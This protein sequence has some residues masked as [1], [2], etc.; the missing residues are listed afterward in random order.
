VLVRD[1]LG[2]FDADSIRVLLLRQHYRESWEYT[3]DQMMAAAEWTAH[4]RSGAAP[5]SDGS[6]GRSGEVLEA[7]EDDLN[8]P[9]ALERMAELVRNNDPGWPVAAGLLGLQLESR[10]EPPARVPGSLG[11]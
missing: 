7:L 9:A 1:L 2:R 11:P 3:E 8:T 10:V 5:P 6:S 4:L